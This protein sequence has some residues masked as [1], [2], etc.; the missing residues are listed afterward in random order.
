MISPAPVQPGTA[1]VRTGEA[2]IPQSDALAEASPDSLSVLMSKD[3]EHYTE[4]NLQDIIRALRENRARF[5]QT[6]AEAQAKPKTARGSASPKAS[7]A[8]AVRKIAKTADEAG[9]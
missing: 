5:A 2:L 1:L 4:Q 8:E 9:F 7:P 3:P 6:E